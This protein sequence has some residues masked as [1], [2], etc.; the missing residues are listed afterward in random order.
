MCPWAT[1]RVSAGIQQAVR[2]PGTE[3]GG[4]LRRAERLGRRES[5]LTWQ[6]WVQTQ[7]LE[8]AAGE[9]AGRH[10]RCGTASC[11][12]IETDRRFSAPRPACREDC[13]LNRTQAMAT[14]KLSLQ[15]L[16]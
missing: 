9:W 10:C 5:K 6:W 4:E 16:G 2:D 8:R 14:R 7:L 12:R 13:S 1:H 11:P 15:E 3:L